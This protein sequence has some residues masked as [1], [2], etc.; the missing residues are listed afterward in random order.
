MWALLSPA[1]S[2]TRARLSTVTPRRYA[3]LRTGYRP[4][5]GTAFAA[6]AH[7]RRRHRTPPGNPDVFRVA[8]AS[9]GPVP[10]R[11]VRWRFTDQFGEAA[12]PAASHDTVC[13]SARPGT[14]QNGGQPRRRERRPHGSPDR[15][16]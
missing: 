1:R 15:G 3:E 2:A 13:R 14:E 10:G 8:R 16:A 9:A 6:G 5:S 4:V 12:E 11:G 7:A